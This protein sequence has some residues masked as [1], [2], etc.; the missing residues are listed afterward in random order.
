[1]SE[2]TVKHHLTR[3]F[4]KTGVFSRLELAMF[5]IKHD[6]GHDTPAHASGSGESV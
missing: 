4:D 6:L 1:L 2:D 5:A 3:V